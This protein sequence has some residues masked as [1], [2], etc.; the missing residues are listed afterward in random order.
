MIS[1]A[2][3]HIKKHDDHTITKFL[4]RTVSAQ[5]HLLG[6]ILALAGLVVLLKLSW[7]KVDSVHFWTCLIFGVTS[8]F[9]F[10]I[11]T[12]YHFISDGYI[13]SKKLDD[14]MEDL[15]HSAIYLFIAGTYTPF[16]VNV[17]NP[18]WNTILMFL[19]WGIALAGILYTHL[20]PH[21]P[22]WAQHRFVNTGIFVL[23]GWTLVVRIGEA[24]DHLSFTSVCLLF[25]GG[26][27]Y[28]IGAAVYATK[29]PDPW[30]NIFGFH[31]I[32]HIFVI[33]GYAFHYLLILN[34]YWI[35][36]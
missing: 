5:L 29:W 18:P 13:I 33:F 34:F 36:V 25:A 7:Q 15:D 35:T 30:K 28:T 21:L 22:L 16:I 24:I 12:V 2:R 26:L 27:S 14:L 32:W 1:Q 6:F 23:M 8:L 9:V 3:R 20:R 17:L 10:G 31:E 11:S 19:I 4:A